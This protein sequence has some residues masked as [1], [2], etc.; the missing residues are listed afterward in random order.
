MRASARE[1]WLSAAEEVGNAS[2]IHHRGQAARRVLEQSREDIARVLGCEPIEVVFTSGGTEAINLAL[3]G[4]WW[5]RTED[6]D[7][8]VLPRAEHH[9]TIDTV[10]WLEKHED[11]RV[12][13]VDTNAFAGVDTSAL[14][15]AVD[16]R[17][18]LVTSLLANNEAGTVNSVG[19]IVAAAGEA[20][21]HLDAVAAFGHLPLEFGKWRTAFGKNLVA[22][23]VSAHKIG[24][25]VS[26][27]ALVASR[28][29]KITALHH[30]GAAQ[31]GLRAG[32][33]DVP[34]AAAF[35]VAAR[36]VE[37]ERNEEVARLRGLRDRL[38]Q[39]TLAIAD[40]IELLGG[41][42]N[43]LP[44][45]AQFH[46]PGAEGESLLFLLDQSNVAVSTGSACQA[47]VAEPS[48]VVLAMGRDERTARS[49]LRVTLGRTSTAEDVE[50]F[51]AAIESAYLRATSS[52]R[53]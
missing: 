26:M 42:E 41:V 11:A 8:I 51:L 17:T 37:E 4:L 13:Q 46:F 29:A 47:G 2:S 35:A 1:A 12:V 43:R 44:G 14:A 34:G 39:G 24:G 21:V 15:G 20:P 50:I 32:T 53:R 48:H 49:V 27:G 31:R 7:S 36:E 16:E 40:G 52:Q 38:V 10:A 9:A 28:D 23:S 25:P 5:S 33:I 22:M 30:G 45:N 19:D 6:Q 18:A 3:K